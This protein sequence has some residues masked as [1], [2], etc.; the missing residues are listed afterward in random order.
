MC[1][2]CIDIFFVKVEYFNSVTIH[3]YILMSYLVL[4]LLIPLEITYE[5]NNNNPF[6]VSIYFM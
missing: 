4:T 6:L 2:I 1:E 5:K 3:F